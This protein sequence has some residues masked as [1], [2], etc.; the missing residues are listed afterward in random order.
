MSYYLC[1]RSHSQ[2][3]DIHLSFL[4][5]IVDLV[6]RFF[7]LSSC[8][9]ALI[10]LVF[11][12]KCIVLQA[13]RAKL[14]IYHSMNIFLNFRGRFPQ[15]IIIHWSILPN[16]VFTPLFFLFCPYNFYLFTGTGAET[17]LLAFTK[18]CRFDYLGNTLVNCLRKKEEIFPL[19]ANHYYQFWT[20]LCPKQ[21]SKFVLITK[22]TDN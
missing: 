7:L 9:F 3:R 2:G 12:F 21:T 15:T 1:A 10:R 8:L 5:Y 19:K 13:I 4:H 6:L 14:T 22:K 18:F 17:D 16:L 20:K 11:E